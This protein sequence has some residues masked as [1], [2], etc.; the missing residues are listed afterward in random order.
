MCSERAA[1]NLSNQVLEQGTQKTVG[2]FYHHTD[3]HSPN[4]SAMMIWSSVDRF[5]ADS[6]RGYENASEA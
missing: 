2:S 6:T 5:P 3:F 4:F 1:L